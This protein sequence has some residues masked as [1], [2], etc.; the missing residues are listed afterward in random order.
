VTGGYEQ[1]NA[2]RR[3]PKARADRRA[4]RASERGDQT[5]DRAHRIYREYVR[6][7]ESAA[8]KAGRR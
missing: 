7:A 3:T 4:R 8:R 2:A 5:S 1:K 6:E